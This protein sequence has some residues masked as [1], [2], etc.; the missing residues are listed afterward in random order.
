MVAGALQPITTPLGPYVR[1]AGEAATTAA[2]APDAG[3]ATIAV[4]KDP[5]AIA[6]EVVATKAVPPLLAVVG[7]DGEHCAIPIRI[8]TRNTPGQVGLLPRGGEV[9]GV[10]VVATPLQMP[11]AAWPP[12]QEVPPVGPLPRAGRSGDAARGAPLAPTVRNASE[13]VLRHVRRAA[14][15]RVAGVAGRLDPQ[16][17]VAQFRVGVPGGGV[18]ATR[19]RGAPPGT[20]RGAAAPPV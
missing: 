13:G 9:P 1:R 8:R 19:V 12:E 4:L 16:V 18:R 15:L 3:A 11:P 14:S 5:A 6:K 7:A 20:R 10:A 2:P 17:A